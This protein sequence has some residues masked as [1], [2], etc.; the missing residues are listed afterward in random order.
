LDESYK[1]VWNFDFKIG[2]TFIVYQS[3]IRRVDIDFYKELMFRDWMNLIRE[4]RIKIFKIGETFIDYG[5]FE[6]G[7]SVFYIMLWLCMSPIDISV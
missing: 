4:F 3:L 6:A 1:R 5:T 2:E 7:L